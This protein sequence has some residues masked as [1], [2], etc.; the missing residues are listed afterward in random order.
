[1]KTVNKNFEKMYQKLFAPN[2]YILPQKTALTPFKFLSFFIGGTYVQIV[3][4]KT[5]RIQ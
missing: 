1:M 2:L 4:R 3:Q 5:K